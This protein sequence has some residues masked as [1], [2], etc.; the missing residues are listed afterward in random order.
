[1]ITNDIHEFNLGDPDSYFNVISAYPAQNDDGDPEEGEVSVM[2][3]WND[4]WGSSEVDYDIYLYSYDYA[5]DDIIGYP[6]N[7]VGSSVDIQDGDDYP[8]EQII[9]DLENYEDEKYYAL[10]VR[11]KSG[12]VVRDLE[13]YLS[14]T[15]TFR[16]FNNSDTAIATSGS[17]LTEPA[18]VESVLA[19]GAIFY[20]DWANGP[21]EEFC[22]Q[23][24][25]NNWSG[26]PARTK[27]DISGPDG[28]STY[29][30]GHEAF[31]G[32]SASTPHV[33]GAAALILSLHPD[34]S[35]AEIRSYIQRNTVDMGADGKDNLYG[36]GRMNL[37]VDASVPDNN[38]SD[39]DGGGC[40]IATAAYGS[41]ME[42][43]VVVL[44][45]FRDDILL[46]SSL[47][48]AFVE[49]YYRYSPPAADFIATHNDLRS[50]ARWG[51]L[52]MVCMSR[53]ALAFGINA[54]L[55]VLAL[56]TILI[57]LTVFMLFKK[58]KFNFC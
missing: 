43:H 35:Q 10:V 21:Q 45:Q 51:L 1:M 30:F 54:V 6:D 58:R 24:P 34:Y 28:T 42:P 50:M 8:I 12:E 13:I 4:V 57:C 15:T 31:F 19:V 3:R 26:V 14:G 48:K 22:S 2:M 20:E 41:Y 36:W 39:G 46:K 18:D 23:G 49:L 47:G 17:S 16:P 25:T 7:P 38:N 33:A 52:P 9:V 27:P 29:T 40:F 37:V 56:T 44:R 32:T 5:N 53:L 55:A 11:K